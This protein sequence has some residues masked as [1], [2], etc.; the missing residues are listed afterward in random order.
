MNP[1]EA[2]IIIKPDLADE[3]RVALVEKFS[4]LITGVGGV[5]EKLDEWGKRRLEYPIE[6]LTAGYYVLINFSAPGDFIH[7][8]ERNLRINEN[9]MRF[10]VIRT[11]E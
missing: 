10:M 9:I 8:F 7:E 1:Y 3:V 5:I 6:F 4:N 11:D 2:M